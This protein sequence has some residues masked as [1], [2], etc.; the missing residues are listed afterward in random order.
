M[1]TQ[2]FQRNQDIWHAI[3]LHKSSSVFD[4]FDSLNFCNQNLFYLKILCL[5]YLRFGSL[6]AHELLWLD[7]H[8]LFLGAKVYSND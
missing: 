3:M 7:S 4:L 2:K 6:C 1:K 8:T 5:I